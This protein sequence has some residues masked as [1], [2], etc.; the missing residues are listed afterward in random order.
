MRATRQVEAAR[1]R[2][3]RQLGLW[4]SQAGYTLPERLPDL[5]AAPRE[6]ARIEQAALERRLDVQAARIAAE[7]TA[8]DLGLTRT[9]RLVNVL[10]L[11]VSDKRETGATRAK[12]Y[13]VGLELP[14]F[15]WG[16]ARVARAEATYM[17][18]LH[19][20]A[21]LAINARSEARDSYLGYRASYDLARH[22]REEFVP[23]RKKIAD[24]TLLRYNGMLASPFELLSDARGQADAV[25][26]YL[27]ALKEFWLA[28]ALLDGALGGRIHDTT[29]AHGA[30]EHQ[31]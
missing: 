29:P 8:A 2:L 20:V 22:Y 6:Q 25:S 1:E 31:P 27:E 10:E 4:G 30:K 7:H 9:T 13:E 3:A 26:G 28:D 23:M 11:G 18:A 12:G 16:G 5:P 21:D 14:L 15:D 24:E 17:Q 19:R